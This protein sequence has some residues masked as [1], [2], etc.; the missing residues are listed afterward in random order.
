VPLV[1]TACF[2]RKRRERGRRSRERRHV[3]CV[4]DLGA[5]DPVDLGGEVRSEAELAQ[6]VLGAPPM[7]DRHDT[8]A[9][10]AALGGPA[11][12]G[13]LDAHRRVDEHAVAVEQNR[14]DVDHGSGN[15]LRDS[16]GSA[17]AD[18]QS[19]VVA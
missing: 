6:R 15:G 17:C 9:V 19:G 5:F 14:R 16:A 18:T 10:E 7:R 2:R 8:V 3:R 4:G 1:T 12:P 11:A 13:P